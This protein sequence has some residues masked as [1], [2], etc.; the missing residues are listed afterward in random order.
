M[1]GQNYAEIL[2][3]IRLYI[4]KYGE[5]NHSPYFKGMLW[6]AKNTGS[7]KLSA[8]DLQE[9]TADF[10]T[11]FE[12]KY[13]ILLQETAYDAKNT[14][15]LVRFFSTLQQ[16]CINLNNQSS[17]TQ[18]HYCLYFPL[19]DANAWNDV[20]NCTSILNEVQRP[21]EI[22]MFG[23]GYDLAE[24]FVGNKSEIDIKQ[25]QKI[26]RETIKNVIDFKKKAGNNLLH[27]IVMQN[28]QSSGVSLNLSEQTFTKV[29]GEFAMLCIENYDD[30]FGFVQPNSE[31][32][33]LGLSVLNL[34]KYY[35][36]EY[37]LHKTY[38]YALERE[39]IK[40][41]EKIEEV[42]INLAT[43]K[44]QEILQNKVS[45]LSEFFNE[46]I[47]KL[48][49][50]NKSHETIVQEVTPILKSKM[51]QIATECE[52]FITDGTLSIPAKRAIFSALLGEDD[53]LFGNQIYNETPL[54][55]DDIDSEAI[56]VYI[57]ANNKL[58]NVEEQKAETVLSDE[59]G[60]PIVSPFP[61][62]KKTRN[63]IIK[64]TYYIRKLEKEIEEL[65]TQVE[66]IEE[67]KKSLTDDGFYE[68]GGT[69]YIL[70]PTIDEI[71]LQ[72]DYKSHTVKST[73]VDLRDGFTPIK[74]QGAVGSCTAFSVT[75][76]F[77][78]I[79][80]SNKQK[81]CDL[82]EAFLFYNARK[83][84]GDEADY[85]KG[86][87]I[88]YAIESLMESGICTEEKWQYK[89]TGSEEELRTFYA[90]EP[91]QEA[92]EDALLRKVK[93]A[94][95]VK[96][97][98][99]DIKSA[100]E[101]GYPVEVSVNLYDS[102]G[103]D[104][105]GIISLPTAEE[106]ANAKTLE[107]HGRHAIVLC[108]YSDETK[109]FIVRNSW[110]TE[111]GDKG[112]CYMPYDYI[113]NPDLTNAAYAI[114]DVA[115]AN[116]TAKGIVKRTALPFGED[117]KMRFAIKKNA[118]AEQERL[119]SVLKNCFSSLKLKYN[120]LHEIILNPHTQTS[121]LD[122][123]QIRL[124]KERQSLQKKYKD[125]CIAMD[126]KLDYF[127]EKTKRKSIYKALPYLIL[128]LCEGLYCYIFKK[129]IKENLVDF[130]GSE[131]KF[132]LNFWSNFVMFA[133][134]T[135]VLFIGIRYFINKRKIIK[136]ELSEEN[137]KKSK[138]TGLFTNLLI[139]TGIIIAI[140][141]FIAYTEN[142][143]E[144]PKNLYDKWFWI[145]L[146]ILLVGS[147]SVG[148]YIWFR[149]RERK[150]MKAEL[151]TNCDECSYKSAL[152]D[153]ERKEN[154]LRM[155]IAGMILAEN[156][157]VE[158]NLSQKYQFMQSFFFN[159]NTW[160]TLEDRSLKTMND[161]V[162]APFIS[163]IN[164]DTLDKYFNTQCD[165]LTK[166][167]SFCNAFSNKYQLSKEGISEFR[168]NVKKNFCE[169]LL[170]SISN[171]SMYD[172]FA[173]PNGQV[174]SDVKAPKELLAEL[175]SKSN[176]FVQH[177]KAPNTSKSVFLSTRNEDEKHNFTRIVRPHFSLL[178][179]QNKIISPLKL[180]LTQ[181]EE[182]SMQDL[183]L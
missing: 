44:A 67:A 160:H 95:N 75:S 116:V 21:V 114:T 162:Q 54:L 2:K 110:G 90:T 17:R 39:G 98:L 169:E 113:A 97:S 78:Y 134:F 43:N 99:E 130:G 63:E 16:N 133:L 92:K 166:N 76:I 53:E 100:L 24:L 164:N 128:I 143:I 170:A 183:Y 146:C 84:A 144:L 102:F 118:L 111:W 107:K 64:T 181:M 171:F 55:I 177:S 140:R 89:A 139:F 136:Q 152:K 131:D 155:H 106:I 13:Q 182:L 59:D 108:G 3:Q 9:E 52:A 23:F 68:F 83:K 161:E 20:K 22:D 33:G 165:E 132:W 28:C 45:I 122:S 81:E 91:N 29:I 62:I 151:Q 156:S 121:L 87:V 148:I 58:L 66:N 137:S 38:L 96:L 112:Y 60:E 103:Q 125:A 94:V 119:L 49:N 168:A 93:K 32:Q 7:I 48:L 47:K 5:D 61:E 127:D 123:T 104:S 50:N 178:P 19:Y 69:K 36:V 10:M 149:I 57:D 159:L 35:Y 56:Q 167:L 41:V 153:K 80:K 145:I 157:K 11:D 42:D 86:S 34:D 30:L 40:G 72:E 105:S 15:E 101:D 142:T 70:L 31:L 85:M 25:C 14:D 179:A 79:L 77:E 150:Q 109:L 138:G 74:N 88:S 173:Q 172:Y 51:Q 176:V 126:E 6:D 174:F 18:L 65:G 71:P 135:V 4:Q 124:T 175:E 141:Y 163:I 120:E 180:I 73:V 82:S 1:F 115:M 117:V 27:F 12:S 129:I 154:K 8:V 147:I 158:H 37:L 26:T 46:E